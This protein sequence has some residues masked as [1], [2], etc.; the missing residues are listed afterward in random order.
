MVAPAVLLAHLVSSGLGP[1]YDGILHFLLT[2]EEAV[3]VLALSLLVGLRGP[4]SGRWALFMLPAA[5]LAGGLAGSAVKAGAPSVT[6]AV[7][8]LALGGLVAADA[9]LPLSSTASLAALVGLLLGFSNG[10]AMAR[11]GL[12]VGALAGEAAA[13]F[14]TVALVSSLVTPSRA[15]W[16]RIVVR[17]AGSWIAAVGMLLLGWS[18]R[19]K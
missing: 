4:A 11:P 19:A 15:L 1:V 17:V 9:P 18:W 16:R 7:L 13:A 6:A 5:W 8:F 14:V 12:G 2:P 3:P 10:A